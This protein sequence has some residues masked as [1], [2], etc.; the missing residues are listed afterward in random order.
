M[1]TPIY[2]VGHVNPDTDSIASAMGY[3]WLLRERD[4]ADTVAARAGAV[5]PQTAWVLKQLGIDAPILLT[6]A[7][8]RFESVMRR[9]DTT[10]PEQPL[11]EAWAIA[12]RTGGIAP[13]LNEDGTPFGL[14]TGRSL[15]NFLSQLVG[16]KFN[17]ADTNIREILEVPCREAADTTIAKFLASGRIR[18]VLNR[19][20][21]DEGDEFWV[22]DEDGLYRG[23]C[24]Q[25]DLLNPPRLKIVMVDQ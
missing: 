15:F 7:S 13:V 25:R 1:T 8:P 3:A 20:L 12:S 11:S 6:D 9:M 23:I 16:P 4:G 2:V 10:T 14:I 19:I 18:D 22:V 21:R 17:R 5:N 24:R